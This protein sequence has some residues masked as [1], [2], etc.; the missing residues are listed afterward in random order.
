MTCDPCLLFNGLCGNISREKEVYRGRGKRKGDKDIVDEIM[1]AWYV[2]TIFVKAIAR[3]VNA[4]GYVNG[5]LSA[6]QVRVTF[7]R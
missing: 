4:R 2:Y 5:G 7:N 6:D 1:S 3:W